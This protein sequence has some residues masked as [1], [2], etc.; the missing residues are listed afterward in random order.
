LGVE[1]VVAGDFALAD[2][3]SLL[4]LASGAVTNDMIKAAIL[5]KKDREGLFIATQFETAGDQP[6]T[7]SLKG[8]AVGIWLNGVQV[9]AGAQFTTQAKRGTN[10][11]VLQLDEGHPPRMLKLT[12]D[13]VS[14]LNP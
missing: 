5:P 11:L 12:S 2:W 4:S 1:R 6:A 8:S 13:D 14:F 7:F 3:Q 9:K 10:N